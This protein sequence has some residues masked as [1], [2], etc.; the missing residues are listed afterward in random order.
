[1][2]EDKKEGRGLRIGVRI[3]TAFRRDAA[4]W[5]EVS[6]GMMWKFGKLLEEAAG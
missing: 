6:E 4:E 3:R 1:M 2:E 5:R